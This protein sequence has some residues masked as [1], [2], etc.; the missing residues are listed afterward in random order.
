MFYEKEKD[1]C[2]DCG[3]GLYSISGECRAC[4]NLRKCVR[5]GEACGENICEDCVDDTGS[6]TLEEQFDALMEYE[7][8]DNA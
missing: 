6:M 3:D 8:R 2:V 4:G 1:L 5:C 7:K